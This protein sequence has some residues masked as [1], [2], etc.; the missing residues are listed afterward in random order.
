MT[1]SPPKPLQID[2]PP[3]E[4]KN[5]KKKKIEMKGVPQPEYVTEERLRESNEGH[6]FQQNRIEASASELAP[7]KQPIIE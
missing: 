7:A 3:D 6:N 5:D 1:I 4:Y 2:I